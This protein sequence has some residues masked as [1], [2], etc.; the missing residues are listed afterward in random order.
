[1]IRVHK[2]AVP[3]GILTDKGTAETSTNRDAYLANQAFYNNG[4]QSFSF[5]SGV[6]GHASVKESL[7]AAQH[8][9]CC[10]CEAKI[11]HISYGDVEHFRPKAGYRQ[12]PEDELG[13]PGYYWLAYDWSNLYLSCQLCNQR[14]KKN[15]FPLQDDHNRCRNHLGD[16]SLEEPLFIDPGALNPED[17]IEFSAEQPVARNG[18]LQGFETIKALGLQREPLRERRFDRYNMLRALKDVAL[19]YPNESLGQR[20][21]AIL[22]NAVKDEAEYSSM[23][24]CLMN[25]S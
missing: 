6:Y 4:T 21:R 10:F 3:P 15:T 9:K 24:R 22:D 11:T 8:G 12:R 5:D 1:M 25:K 13:R 7:I 20:A 23:A 19:L 14:H 17:H 18:S 16:L 2:P